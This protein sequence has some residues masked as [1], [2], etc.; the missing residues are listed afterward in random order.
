[1]RDDPLPII[2]SPAWLR[3]LPDVSIT[4]TVEND[5]IKLPVHVPNGTLVEITLPGEKGSTGQSFYD[6]ARE[7][8]GMF[9]GPADLS[10]DP[11]HLE[12]FGG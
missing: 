4:A 7:Y 5:I 11:R 3:H 2:D 8:I 12:D 1:M 9:D 6:G 10:T